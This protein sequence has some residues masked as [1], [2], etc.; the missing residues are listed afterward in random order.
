MIS[1]TLQHNTGLKAYYFNDNNQE[2]VNSPM[3]TPLNATDN[4]QVMWQRVVHNIIP[5]QCIM[6]RASSPPS[7]PDETQ[8]HQ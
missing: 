6:G 2:M 1:C 7:P 8:A 3:P 4:Q 5:S